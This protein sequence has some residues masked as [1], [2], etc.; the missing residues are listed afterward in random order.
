MKLDDLGT[1][2]IV[3]LI[4]LAGLI[5]AIV[6]AMGAVKKKQT[7]KD[8]PSFWGEF[9][10]AM[11]TMSQEGQGDA[12]EAEPESE[13]DMVLVD[14][15]TGRQVEA[16]AGPPELEAVLVVGFG[17]YPTRREFQQVLSDRSLTSPTRATEV[18]AA[19]GPRQRPT[20]AE[21]IARLAATIARRMGEHRLG[22]DV[23]P[24]NITA[25]MRGELLVIKLWTAPVSVAPVAPLAPADAPEPARHRPE[26]LGAGISKEV[27]DITHRPIEDHLKERGLA[28]GA[29]AAAIT[30]HVPAAVAMLHLTGAASEDLRRAILLQEILSQPLAE[31]YPGPAGLW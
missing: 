6:N 5:K 4:L 25:E 8:R 11:K 17:R 19:L 2:I 14:E 18:L 15:A 30:R 28:G 27:Q 12:P 10:K 23:D 3:L 22:Y 24:R 9:K 26:D 31:R 7:T 13:E 21:E 16:P 29:E 20:T 1:I